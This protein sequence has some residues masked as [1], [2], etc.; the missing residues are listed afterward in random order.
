MMPNSTEYFRNPYA[1]FRGPPSIR[2]RESPISSYA[3]DLQNPHKKTND[4]NQSPPP[5]TPPPTR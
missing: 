2:S 5:T 4:V 1:I 3:L